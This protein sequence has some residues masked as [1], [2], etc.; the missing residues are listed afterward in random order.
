M[1]APAFRPR[2]TQRRAVL[3]IATVV[4]GAIAVGVQVNRDEA[5]QASRPAQA[6]TQ[7]ASPSPVPRGGERQAAAVHGKAGSG[8]PAGQETAAES[9][10]RT[11]SAPSTAPR[12]TP[13]PAPQDDDSSDVGFGLA[14]YGP[15]VYSLP[16]PRPNYPTNPGAGGTGQADTTGPI[17]VIPSRLNR[18]IRVSRNGV[19]FFTLGAFSEDVAG[20]MTFTTAKAVTTGI[21][22]KRKK[23]KQ[24]VLLARKSGLSIAA[25]KRVRIRV[26]LRKKG[27]RTLRKHKQ[28]RTTAQIL[29]S[30]RVGNLS[31]RN[32]TFTLKAP[33]PKKKK[34][35]SRH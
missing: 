9:S 7:G 14:Q 16:P 21:A 29:L 24:F 26:K 4:V 17:I 10:V 3:A 23:K 27:F 12:S 15:G 31:R 33:K 11:A 25:K 2:P 18:V 30:D 19:F 20:A 35:S 5:R 28:L 6:A 13:R 32:F 1:P 22:R 34:K 8:L